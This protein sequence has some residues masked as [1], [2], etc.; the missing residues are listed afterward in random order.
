MSSQSS[1][2]PS[3]LTQPLDQRT[4]DKFKKKYQHD[5]FCKYKLCNLRKARKFLKHVLK[6]EV[7]KLVDLS[8]LRIDPETYVDEELKRLYADVLYRI[9]LKNS[10]ETLVVFILIELKTQNDQW[11]IFQI[12][13]YVVRIWDR[14]FQAVESAVKAPNANDE[15]KRRFDNFLLPMVIP[16]IFHYGEHPFT[17]PTELI[18]LIQR[19]PEMDEFA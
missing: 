10:D 2:H 3:P 19:L 14:E 9:P 17:S 11:T 18:E 5:A 13:K 8:K 16:I 12:V 4:F 1:S 6:P 7:L 15:A